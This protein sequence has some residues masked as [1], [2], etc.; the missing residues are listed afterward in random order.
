MPAAASLRG[1]R[2]GLPARRPGFDS[3]QRA[4]C[5][6]LHKYLARGGGVQAR[7][8]RPGGTRVFCVFRVTAISRFS[9][10][11]FESFFRVSTVH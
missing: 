11:T 7:P 8:G 4:T 5:E 6:L 3:S 1:R 10:F 9:D 2:L